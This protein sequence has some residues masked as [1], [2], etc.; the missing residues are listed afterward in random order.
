MLLKWKPGR[1][2][3]HE[4][5]RMLKWTEGSVRSTDWLC[6]NP[7]P[8]PHN[9]SNNSKVESISFPAGFLHFLCLLPQ[10]VH[11]PFLPP[12]KVTTQQALIN[13]IFFFESPLEKGNLTAVRQNR[14]LNTSRPL[15]T[16]AQPKN[17]M[18][19][20]MAGHSPELLV[21]LGLALPRDLCA[22][23]KALPRSWG[24]GVQV[25]SSPCPSLEPFVFCCLFSG[26]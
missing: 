12:T 4:L 20:S 23:Q 13:V 11:P 15:S 21:R 1:T 18:K 17:K 10:T 16:R 26:W 2:C 5:V 22:E 25:S 14:E 8:A 9:C 19:K 7:G 3:E 6:P 24:L